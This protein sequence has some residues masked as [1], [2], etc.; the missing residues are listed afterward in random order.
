MVRAA[1]LFWLGMSGACSDAPPGESGPQPPPPPERLPEN[2]ARTDPGAPCTTGMPAASAFCA[3]PFEETEIELVSQ[4]STT[5]AGCTQ[6]YVAS[7]V[8]GDSVARVRRYRMTGVDPCGFSRD[9]AFGEA[10]ANLSAIS[11]TND[12]AVFALGY[13]VLRRVAPGP[14]VDCVANGVDL[15]SDALLAVAPSGRVGWV[16]WNLDDIPQFARLSVDSDACELVPL[17]LDER[18]RGNGPVV[19]ITADA[20]EHLHILQG[21]TSFFEPA[22]VS[23]VDVDGKTVGNYEPVK[24]AGISWSPRFVTPCGAG[25]CVSTAGQLGAFGPGGEPLG[26]HWVQVAAP[27]PPSD[28]SF[29]QVSMVGSVGGPLM[30]IGRGGPP[31]QGMRILL[32]PLP[33]VA[34]PDRSYP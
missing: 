32:M 31:H 1:L 15:Q 22:W 6:L 5:T 23:V 33:R 7:R 9:E 2:D 10:R 26:W 30:A 34:P 24:A 12:G 11:A 29:V 17:S 4:S 18:L 25:T 20:T 14:V 13:R 3:L 8:P 19:A 28:G 21:T 16:V 27:A